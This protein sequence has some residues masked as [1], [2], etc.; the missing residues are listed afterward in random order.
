MSNLI[1]IEGISGVGKSTI[2]AALCERLRKLGGSVNYYPEGDPDHPLDLFYVS[3]L[4]L[5]EYRELLHSY[6][7]WGNELQK[8]SLVEPDY[9]L[10][11]Y[12]DTKRTYYSPELFKYLK[13]YEFCYNPK[14]TLPLS[15]YSMVFI[16]LWRRFAE[17][18]KTSRNLF[19]FDG[20]LL[21]H[22][23]NDLTRNY[24]ATTDQITAYLNLL[25]ETIEHLNPVVFY[26]SLQDIRGRLTKARQS[27]EQTPPTDE[28]ILFWQKRKK[29][30]LSVLERLPVKSHILDISDD[31]WDFALDN[32]V[33]AL[34]V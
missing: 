20:S 24:D 29:I 4:T 1:F 3:Y 2:S 14:S 7:G 11:R 9:V 8:N 5:D 13:E 33:R 31:N 15:K 30:D 27:R 19:I 28:Q 6:P 32:I 26:L 12:Q 34:W 22:Q 17:N 23:I 10:V 16:N 21:M 25:L 18:K